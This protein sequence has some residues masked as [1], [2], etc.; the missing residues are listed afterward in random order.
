MHLAF[1]P[2]GDGSD[3]IAK[4]EVQVV[5]ERGVGVVLYVSDRGRIAALLAP[6][7]RQRPVPLNRIGESR[8]SL[9]ARGAN[10]TH[11][12]PD[13]PRY[14]VD[15]LRDNNLGVDLFL[16]AQG[17][18][19][20]TTLV[21]DRVLTQSPHGYALDVRPPGIERFGRDARRV[22]VELKSQ[23]GMAFYL[24]DSGDLAPAP[25]AIASSATVVPVWRRGH[26][27]PLPTLDKQGP[28]SP[29][30]AI[31]VYEDPNSG[32]LIYVNHLGGV[33]AIPLRK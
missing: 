32:S 7:L 10:E 22:R 12:S 14:V 19:L 3:P 28:D 21:D 11:L 26:E 33:A 6:A 4:R 20:V 13:S 8:Y 23:P 17:G 16:A 24:V 1:Q 15:A 5:R 9:A 25:A 27:V 2:K 31:E 29:R 18:I 30:L